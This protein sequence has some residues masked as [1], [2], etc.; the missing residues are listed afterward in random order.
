[1][2][3]ARP[4]CRKPPVSPRTRTILR[5]SMRRILALMLAVAAVAAAAAPAHAGTYSTGNTPTVR[6]RVG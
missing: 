4:I 1:M 2:G 5:A 3:C 6:V